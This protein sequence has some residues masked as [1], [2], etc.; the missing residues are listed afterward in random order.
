VLITQDDVE[1]VSSSSVGTC[2][3]DPWTCVVRNHIVYVAT[4]SGE[5]FRLNRLVNGWKATDLLKEYDKHEGL[6][7]DL[8]K[9]AGSISPCFADFLRIKAYIWFETARVIG[10]SKKLQELELE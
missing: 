7:D 9:Q 8:I 2:F 6:A 3:G 1:I 5:A 10:L 4:L